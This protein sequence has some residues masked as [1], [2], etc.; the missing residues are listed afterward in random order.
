MPLRRPESALVVIYDQ[1]GR[2]LVLQR[3]DDSEFW[4]SVTGTLEPGEQAS[5]TALR[6][7]LEETSIDIIDSAYTL[8]DHQH[9]N[10][11]IIRQ[12]WQHR[13][14]AGT[15]TNTEHVFSVQVAGEDN[16][17]L[18]EHTAYL[19]LNKAEAMAKVWSETNRQ[20]IADYVPDTQKG[21]A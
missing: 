11:Y 4:Q 15:T 9:T 10:Q 2:V 14:P 20:A 12:R 5:T 8:L 19:W 16:I 3:Q 6:E 7:V 18:S 21:I 1:Q 13:Y 17:Q